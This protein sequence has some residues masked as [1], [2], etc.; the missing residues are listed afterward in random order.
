[1]K[2]RMVKRPY[3]NLTGY[4][5]EHFDL[6]S[7]F[8]EETSSDLGE[9]YQV[10]IPPDW[11]LSQDETWKYCL[12]NECELPLQGWKIHLSSCKGK[13]VEL[14]DLVLPVLINE[15]VPFKY[16]LST[17]SFYRASS[18]YAARS[19]SGK[20]ITVYPKDNDQFCSLLDTLEES[21]SHLDGPYILSDTQ[22]K[23]GPVFFRYGGFLYRRS[24]LQSGRQA[25][26][27]EGPKG[28]VVEDIRAPFFVLPEF[29]EVPKKI[30]K[31]VNERLNPDG[32]EL[33]K[34][35]APYRVLKSLHF[36]NG[37]GVYE[38][39]DVVGNQKVVLK[40]A[41]PFAG[42]TNDDDAITRLRNEA[43][44]LK[45]L[46]GLKG[47]PTYLDYKK[48]CGHE[49]LIESYVEGISLQNWLASNY[50]F[51]LGEKE[52]ENFENAALSIVRQVTVLIE[53]IH[54]RG[55]A[56]MD[57]NIK[58]FIVDG[59]LN[60]GIVDFEGCRRVNGSDGGVLGTP[61]FVP[62]GS[63]TN[64]ERD[65]FGLAAVAMYVFLPSWSA[66]FSPAVLVSGL[67][68]V[69]KI[70]SSRVTDLLQKLVDDVKPALL[71]PRFQFH[72]ICL[73]KINIGK[74]VALL[75]KGIR[76][77]SCLLRKDKGLR[78]YPAD[79]VQFLRG[80]PGYLNIETGAAG[81]MLMLHRAG[82]DVHGDAEWIIGR[83]NNVP[84]TEFHGLLYGVAG[85]ATALSQVGYSERAMALLP[86]KL[87]PLQSGDVSIRSGIS[88]T[89]LALCQMAS[90][91]QDVHLV[92]LLDE[93]ACELAKIIDS[94]MEP[95]SPYSETGNAVG[96]F[97]GWSGAAVACKHLSNYYSDG[98]DW[99]ERMEWCLL[100][101]AERMAKGR[102]GLYVDYSGV[103]FGYL[104]EGT[105]GVLFALHYCAPSL[106]P[107]E[108]DISGKELCEPVSLNG[109]LF[110]GLSGKL[111]VLSQIDSLASVDKIQVMLRGIVDGFLFEREE[112]GPVYM[113]GDGGSC[114]STDYS[115]G[116]SGLI[117]TLLSLQSG[118]CEWFPV[119]L[120]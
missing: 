53:Q 79:A 51:S 65:A 32:S 101:E 107:K 91:R 108:I 40:E 3:K 11:S 9:E 17:A 82:F 58:N 81:N 73:E 35:L 15:Q 102:N 75:G 50:P 26:V 4:R 115:T 38:G 104:S 66:S 113:L 98:K 62:Y 109:G 55:L 64:T 119:P 76:D 116:S 94:R 43:D 95:V 28:T 1:M 118:K 30:K 96:L 68:R 12:P 44:S 59:S 21:V 48:A 61:G 114:L 69:A 88:G 74:M 63:C 25:V 71:V 54:K 34:E 89:V 56:I 14:L 92:D 42:Y 100:A 23:K 72:T 19:G 20:F 99:L 49:F 27:I 39:L 22:F 78:R 106:W 83:V 18:K 80:L 52:V 87:P 31:Q 46:Q 84:T 37:G 103:N 117:G 85:I 41:R 24:I 93:A 29:V 111:A 7:P 86:S 36:S 2:P 47:V 110:H 8:Y 6:S 120:H 5:F 112:G 57:I 45:N 70:F 16:R 10:E 13:E 67:S 90:E 97:D 33:E 77:A 105:A 60:V